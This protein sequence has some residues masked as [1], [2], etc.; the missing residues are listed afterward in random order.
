MFYIYA[1][2]DPRTGN[3]FYIGKG[4]GNRK[5]QHLAAVKAGRFDGNQ[6][7]QDLIKELLSIGLEPFSFVIKD[8]EFEDQAIDAEAE[9]IN[10][11]SGLTNR[12]KVRSDRNR[13]KLYIKEL[14]KLFGRY[15]YCMKRGGIYFPGIPRELGKKAEDGLFN[16]FKE[17]FDFMRSQGYEVVRNGRS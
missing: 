14:P 1:L 7:K 4:Q 13:V 11:L 16:F 5:D 17:A 6:G 3:P 8:F 15:E 9:L 12:K 2:I 10:S